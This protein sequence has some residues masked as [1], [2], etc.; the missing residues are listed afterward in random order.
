MQYAK[1]QPKRGRYLLLAIIVIIW[2]R[3]IFVGNVT[4][5]KNIV[6][7]KW[8]SIQSFVMPLSRSE[9]LRLKI[10][11]ATHKVDTTKIQTGTYTFSGSYSTSTYVETIT[12]WPTNDYIR[13][14]TLEGWS[15]YDID[16]DMSAKWIIAT[17]E[18]LTK[19]QDTSYIQSLITKYPFLNQSKP[20]T[21]LEGFLYPDT[22]FLGTNA[23][24]IESL[25]Q[26]S[27]KRFNEKIYSLR[28]AQS[29]T[30][31]SKLQTKSLTLSLQWALALW[32]V[33]EKEERNNK[34]KPTI[35]W[36]F[37]NR[38]SQ[39]IQLG[40]DISLC[41]GL[42]QPYESCTPS[43]IVNS[44]RDDTN[45]Y[46]TRVQKWLPPTPIASVTAETMQA[47]LNFA[48]TSYLF[49]LHDTK[50]NIYYAQTNAQHEENKRLY[51]Q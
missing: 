14:T 24:P 48:D 15:L 16:A 42:K 25:I 1:K 13:Y 8:E 29:A 10:Y 38:L 35:A 11:L 26:A 47:L 34:E 45:P 31:T 32:S 33:I 37:I 9:K 50:G 17:G 12:A 4:P 19:A 7:Q 3:I 30:F 36:I 6:L 49:Y 20:L 51:M 44:L 23:D 22:Y 41:Y 40:A 39:D 43:Q 27:L 18:L 28:E 5:P 2:Y 21:T 46:N